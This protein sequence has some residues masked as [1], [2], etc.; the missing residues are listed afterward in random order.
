MSTDESHGESNELL[1]GYR[2]IVPSIETLND[3]QRIFE[4]RMLDTV[5]YG[6]SKIV[7]VGSSR[8]A[9][10]RAAERKKKDGYLLVRSSGKLSLSL[11]AVGG[12]SPS[13]F[14]ILSRLLEK[15]ETVQNEETALYP[16]T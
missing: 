10:G 12:D 5:G 9:N 8:A 16:Y 1:T 6:R 14:S 11:R 7:T 15:G 2:L 4:S 3:S 13:S